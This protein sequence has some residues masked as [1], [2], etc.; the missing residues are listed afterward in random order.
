M[1]MMRMHGLNNDN[2]DGLDND[3]EDG[4][5]DDDDGDSDAS[6]LDRRLILK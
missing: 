6:R 1:T 2:E 4:H 5:D 3:E